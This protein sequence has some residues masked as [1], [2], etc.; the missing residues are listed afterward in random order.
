MAFARSQAQPV[1]ENAPHPRELKALGVAKAAPN[2]GNQRRYVCILQ[3]RFVA[4]DTSLF[5]ELLVRFT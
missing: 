5:T 4:V 2:A 1:D 3:A